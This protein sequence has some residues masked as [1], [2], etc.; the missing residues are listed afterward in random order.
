MPA[1]LI[2]GLDLS[3]GGLGACAVPVD[4]ASH[5]DV[6]WSRMVFKTME[7]QTVSIGAR[8]ILARDVRTFIRSFGGAVKAVWAEDVPRS[9]H[10]IIAL[11]K[12]AAIVELDLLRDLGIELQ[13]ANQSSARLLM[14]G[15]GRAPEGLTKTQ[16][17]AWVTEPLALAGAQFRTC[18]LYTSDAADD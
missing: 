4:F 7:E 8:E 5:G 3:Y 18:L 15:R 14:F 11:A 1:D 13:F 9:G 17:K 12:L 10:Q 2:V 6:N 16:R